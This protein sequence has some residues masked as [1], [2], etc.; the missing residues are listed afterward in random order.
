[1][2]Q[3]MV[4]ILNNNTISDPPEIS[5]PPRNVSLIEGRSTTIKCGY[6]GDDPIMVDWLYE[7]RAVTPSSR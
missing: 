4:N 2:I 7:G 5:V 3:I 1:M 6:T